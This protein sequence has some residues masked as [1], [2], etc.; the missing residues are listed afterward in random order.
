[1]HKK[2]TAEEVWAEVSTAAEELYLDYLELDEL[3]MFTLL[4]DAPEPVD[5]KRNWDVPTGLEIWES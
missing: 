2:L 5:N 4:P 3:D 1:M